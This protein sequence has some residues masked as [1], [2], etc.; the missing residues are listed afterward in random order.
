MLPTELLAAI[1]VGCAVFLHVEAKSFGKT[2]KVYAEHLRLDSLAELDDDSLCYF[3]DECWLPETR[4]RCPIKCS[5]HLCY[6][7]QKH[8]DLKKDC[9][10]VEEAREVCPALCANFTVVEK[11]AYTTTPAPTTPSVKNMFSKGVTAEDSPDE[12][13]LQASNVCYGAKDDTPG[14]FTIKAEGLLVGLK[15][16]HKSGS[17][18]CSD[19]KRTSRWGCKLYG[20]SNNRIYT[21]VTDERKEVVFPDSKIVNSKDGGFY[22][23]PLF[24]GQTA[25]NLVFVNTQKPAYAMKGSKL[26]VWYGSDLY[27]FS[28]SDNGGKHCIDVYATFRKLQ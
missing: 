7:I 28:E 4:K 14:K 17:L 3:D 16:V 18:F 27:D 12:W 20:I 15:L 23:L 24:N 26:S 21:I 8:N 13:Q 19:S 9:I 5:K 2:A 25:D 22:F 6:Y 10:D 1:L 11:K